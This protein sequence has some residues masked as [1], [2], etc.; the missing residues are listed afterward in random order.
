MLDAE[1]INTDTCQSNQEPFW[2]NHGQIYW[3]NLALHPEAFNAKAH[4]YVPPKKVIPVIF[5]PG[6]MGSN[7]MSI[8]EQDIEKNTV[9]RGDSLSKVYFKWAS[10]TGEERRELLD[11]LNTTVDNNGDISSE[12]YSLITD[13]G[14]GP[15]G[16]ML[17]SRRKRGWGKVLNFS[18]GNSLSVLQAALLDDWQKVLARRIEGKSALSEN[19]QENGILQQLHGKKLATED[20]IEDLLTEGEIK[21]F[22]NFLFPLHVFG[23]NWLEDNAESAAKLLTFIDDVL[24]LYQYTHGHG[25]ALNKVILVTHSMGGLVARYAS[26]VL[27]GKDKILGIVHGVIPDLG[28]PAAYRRMKVGAAQE[29]AAGVVMGHSA[30]E[31]MPVLANAPAP[32]QLLPAPNY[33]SDARGSWLHIEK[34]ATDGSELSLPKEGKPF[35]EIYLDKTLWWRL[36]EADILDKDEKVIKKNWDKYV[37]LV[38]DK[39]RIF[40]DKLNTAGYHPTTYVFYGNKKKSD[41]FL[42]WK[43]THI[44]YPKN[45]HESDKKIPNNYRDI[46]LPYA[47]SRLYQLVPSN[48]PGDSTVP[49]ES[50]KR[51]RSLNGKMIKSVLATDVDHQG[52]YDVESLID[53]HRRPA[54]HFTLRAIVKMVQE[55]PFSP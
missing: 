20:K 8:K 36:Y 55:V 18:Y 12:V 13:D 11:P 50:L 44:T 54:L 33:T 40:I 29:G 32:L 41:G 22:T 14:E 19:P 21:H 48:T 45:M 24:K 42:Q 17:P 52:A 30:K 37:N 23:Y 1:R 26:Q 6:V 47:R 39:V 4:C 3:K 53:I 27:G 31:L 46:P 25:L 15:R 7:L 35:E 16:T 51:I 9:W 10:K 28:S 34:G 2:S 38:E 43:I 5:L 49:I